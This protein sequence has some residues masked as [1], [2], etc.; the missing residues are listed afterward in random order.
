MKYISQEQWSE[1]Q[2]RYLAWWANGLYKRPLMKVIAKKPPSGQVPEPPAPATPTDLYLDID[3]LVQRARYF[4][5]THLYMGDT[6]PDFEVGLG[7]GTLALYLGSQPDFAWDTVWF[8]PCMEDIEEDSFFTADPEKYWFKKQMGMYREAKRRLG[9]DFIYTIPDMIENIDILS[10]MRGAEPLCI[11][12]LDNPDA[13]KRHIR[14]IDELYEYYYNIIYDFVKFPDDSSCFSAFR[15]W[16][17]GRTAKIQCDFA[18]LISPKQFREFVQ[19]SLQREC[20]FMNNTV[21]HLD[22]P[23]AM[24]HV[25]ALMEIRELRALQFTCGEMRPDGTNEEWYSVY[26]QVKAAGKALWIQVYDGGVDQWM[27]NC[28]RFIKRYGVCG[29]YFVFPDFEDEKTAQD[30]MRKA[31]LDWH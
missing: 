25:P 9:D 13:V 4:A 11:D 29:L 19:P 15:V 27:K 7:P 10:A 26:D 12:M 28:D 14:Q 16:G 18:A 31:E 22:G 24:K 2:K 5:D 23:Q 20:K 21:F 8:K 6:Y 30:I 17:P 1:T 3:Y